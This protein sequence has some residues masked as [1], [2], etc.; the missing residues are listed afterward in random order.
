M[1]TETREE[2]HLATKIVIF[3][4]MLLRSKKNEEID[5]LRNEITKMKKSLL[6]LQYARLAV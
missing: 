6:N 1:F 2:R 4:D 5:R 3:E